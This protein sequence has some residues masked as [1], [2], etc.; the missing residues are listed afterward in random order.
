M[1]MFRAMDASLFGVLIYAGWSTFVRD[2]GAFPA[3]LDNMSW[4]VFWF[5]EAIILI[6]NALQDLRGMFL[7]LCA[8]PD[9]THL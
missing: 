6:N 5:I 1:S 3:L 7:S 2:A 4:S 9:W 8:T